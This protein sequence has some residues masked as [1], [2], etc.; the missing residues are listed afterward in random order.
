MNQLHLLILLLISYCSHSLCR[1]IQTK[2]EPAL[3]VVSYDGFKPEYLDRN[4]T[5]HLEQFREMGTSAEYM[6]PVFPTKTFINHFTIAT[7]S[8]Q[9]IKVSQ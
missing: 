2:P 4:I 7:V 8:I 1:T 9:L 5:P 6:K 3:L